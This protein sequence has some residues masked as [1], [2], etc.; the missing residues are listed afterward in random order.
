[1]RWRGTR[2]DAVD[3]D[4]HAEDDADKRAESPA[5]ALLDCP[6]SSHHILHV[7][8]QHGGCDGECDGDGR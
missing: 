5:G 7:A 8:D 3:H 4:Q 1:M 2:H 6:D